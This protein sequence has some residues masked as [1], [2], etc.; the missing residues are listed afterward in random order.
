M[1]IKG[2]GNEGNISVMTDFAAWQLLIELTVIDQDYVKRLILDRFTKSKANIYTGTDK[3]ILHLIKL[4]SIRF[5]SFQLQRQHSI[6]LPHHWWW[7]GMLNA[8]PKVT[9]FRHKR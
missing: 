4:N 6:P 5:G 7:D 8:I 9:N 1:L 2:T 3:I